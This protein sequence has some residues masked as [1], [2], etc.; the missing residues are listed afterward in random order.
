MD[1][2]AGTY[3]LD[4]EGKSLGNADGIIPIPLYKGM[5]IT[6]HAHDSI[7]EVVDWNYHHGHPDEHA[8]LRIILKRKAKY[9]L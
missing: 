1:S 4:E 8:G 3:F 5:E 9:L 6:I 7:F 2:V